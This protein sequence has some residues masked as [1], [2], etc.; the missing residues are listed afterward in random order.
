VT[1]GGWREGGGRGR[2]KASVNAMPL[3]VIVDK[4]GSDSSWPLLDR[5][6]AHPILQNFRGTKG[7]T[8]RRSW[9]TD[10]RGRTRKAWTNGL[11]AS[12][13]RKMLRRDG[14]RSI[15]LTKEAQG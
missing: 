2:G 9:T 7:D 6:V 12:P 10:C 14:G 4:C 8:S 5:G 3:E 1:A 11:E 13:R 15:H